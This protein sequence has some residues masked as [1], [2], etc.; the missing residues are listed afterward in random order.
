MLYLTFVPA[1]SFPYF[2]QD[3]KDEWTQRREK[4]VRS[5]DTIDFIGNSGE[6]GVN[7]SH[8]LHEIAVCQF[9]IRTL[10]DLIKVQPQDHEEESMQAVGERGVEMIRDLCKV[11]RQVE[12]EIARVT[13]NDYENGSSENAGRDF[14]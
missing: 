1:E 13:F 3:A 7:V 12:M 8:Y 4:A 9:Y 6:N 2:D 10:R 5:L 14:P 11:Q